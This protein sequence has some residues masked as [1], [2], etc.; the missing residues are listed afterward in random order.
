MNKLARLP[1]IDR[2]ARAST[3]HGGSLRPDA[4]YFA[5]LSYS[6]KDRALADWLHQELEQFR[7]PASLVGQ[8]TEHGPIPKRLTPIFRDQHELAAA[9]DLGEEI[10]HALANS[11]FLIVLCSPDAARS[12]WTNAEIEAFKRY[13]PDACVLAAIAAGEPFASEM[14]GG[15]TDECFPP[16]L[17][18]KYDRR[19]RPTSRRAEPLAA[20]LRGNNEERRLGLLKL[21]AGMLGV[22]LDDLVQ[23]DAKRRQRRL[24]LLAAVALAGMAVTS[25][26]ALTAIHARDAAREQRREAEGLVAFMLGDLKD[27]LEPIGRLDALDGVGA[28][29]L[30]Y[31][32]KEDTSGLSDA[33]LSQRAQALSLMAE[34]ASLRGDFTGASRLYREA[35]AGTEEAIRRKP[36][37]PQRLFDH[38]Q[39]VFYFGQMRRS[40]G[41]FR[42][43]EAAMREYKRLALQMVALDPNNMKWRMEQQYA[44]V[45]LGVVL[46]DQERYAE[47]SRQFEDGLRTIQAISTADPRNP[48]YRQSVAE[49]LAWLADSLAAEGR[50]GDAV[51]ARKRGIDTLN[52]LFA[53][54]RS[55]DYQHRLIP[56]HRTLAILYADEGRLDLAIPE[57]HAALD[58]AAELFPLEPQNTEWRESASYAQFDLAHYAL[59]S[60]ARGEAQ[61]AARAGCDLVS[62]LLKRDSTAAPW[63]RALFYCLELRSEL[64]A[65]EHD[66]AAAS[67]YATRALGVARRLAPAGNAT[68]ARN[69][70]RAYRTSGDLT[71]RADPVSARSAWTSGLAALPATPSTNPDELSERAILLQRL[72]RTADSQAIVQRL[73]SIGYRNPLYLSALRGGTQ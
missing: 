24:A 47:A 41:D 63:Q 29:V 11:H 22:G 65:A 69:L 72:G 43:S 60:G 7:V 31:Y 27:K 4:R 64:A 21:I 36:S 53:A 52:Q 19:G 1:A 16:A 48:D 40:L 61:A 46:E 70:A 18:L 66:D 32:S 68:D 5:F 39:N 15:E 44:E 49:T 14:P 58:K 38:A 12:R 34:V 54:T 13:K 9:H 59:V 73:A 33:A 17:R 51:V 6:H 35:M 62:A 26:L 57:V 20:D 71:A 28:K 10:Q 67:A 3:G 56:A 45:N 23:R 25:G 50:T 8:L 42:V 2:D 30:A 55:V 37:D